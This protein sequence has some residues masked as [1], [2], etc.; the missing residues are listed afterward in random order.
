MCLEERRQR[1]RVRSEKINWR[2]IIVIIIV[3]VVFARKDGFPIARTSE[4]DEDDDEDDGEDEQSPI[5]TRT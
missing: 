5:A 3:T 4:V 1:R 2:G